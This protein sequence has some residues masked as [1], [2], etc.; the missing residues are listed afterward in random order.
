MSSDFNFTLASWFLRNVRVKP[1]SKH[2][3]PS[4]SKKVKPSGYPIRVFKCVLGLHT[5]IIWS[6]ITCTYYY[7][8]AFRH[9]RPFNRVYY[10]PRL[11]YRVYNVL[12][13]YP[14]TPFLQRSRFPT[15][16]WEVDHPL[17]NVCNQKNLNSYW[18]LRSNPKKFPSRRKKVPLGLEDFAPIFGKLTTPYVMFAIEKT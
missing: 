15:Y 4:S 7:R 2:S 5:T 12:T 16:F 14:Q 8:A 3:A 1:Y 6:I 10:L 18:I 17:C 11:I 9:R 13:A